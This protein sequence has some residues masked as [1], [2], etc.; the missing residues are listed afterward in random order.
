M[1]YIVLSTLKASCV[2]SWISK[3]G[4]THKGSESKQCL[5]K[6]MVQGDDTIPELG[7]LKWYVMV[8]LNDLQRGCTSRW[9]FDKSLFSLTNPQKKLD[10]V[11]EIIMC[12]III[13]KSKES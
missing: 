5:Y 13:I 3:K 12:E 7:V 10:L 1:W 11:W 9:G 8:G 2:L 6:D 4:Q